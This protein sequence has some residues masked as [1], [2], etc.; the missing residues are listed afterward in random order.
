MDIVE[1]NFTDLYDKIGDA[2]PIADA[3]EKTVLTETDY[4][5][6]QQSPYTNDDFRKVSLANW[7]PKCNFVATTA[8]TT[9]DDAAH[10]YSVGSAWFN[11]TTHVWYDCVVA[12]TNAALW[13]SRVTPY[14]AGLKYSTWEGV[15]AAGAAGSNVI[16]TMYFLPYVVRHRVTIKSLY[17]YAQNAGTAST[18]KFGIYADAEGASGHR[19]TGSPLAA[20]NTGLSTTGTGQIGATL[21]SQSVSDLDTG[22]PRILWF[23]SKSEGTTS[24]GFM[25]ASATSYRNEALFGRAIGSSS[26]AFTGVTCTDANGNLPDVTAKSFTEVTGNT[27]PILGFGL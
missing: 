9:T 6:I 27:I 20:L 23:A 8:P 12:T 5:L 26:A 3:V 16:N 4:V 11:T 18:V 14:V 24:A 17:A 1:Q 10:G 2:F 7:G 15:H 22:K 13:A 19:P 21:A 25:C